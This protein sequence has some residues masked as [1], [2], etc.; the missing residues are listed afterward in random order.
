MSRGIWV[1]SHRCI[2]VVE[3][4][5]GL[6]I[7]S[8]VVHATGLPKVDSFDCTQQTNRKFYAILTIGEERRETKVAHRSSALEWSQLFSLYECC[9]CSFPSCYWF[10]ELLVSVMPTQIPLWRSKYLL[11]ARCARTSTLASSRTWYLSYVL[12]YLKT[13]LKV[14]LCSIMFGLISDTYVSQML[15]RPS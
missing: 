11:T 10:A 4:T 6:L 5:H 7:A 8:T 13:A 2:Q 9:F 3:S 12:Q 15:P 1:E 14:C